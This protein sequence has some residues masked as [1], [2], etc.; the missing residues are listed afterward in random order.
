MRSI[1]RRAL[2]VCVAACVCAVIVGVVGAHVSTAQADGAGAPLASSAWPAFGHDIQMTRRSPYVGA[3]TNHLKWTRTTGAVTRASAAIGPDGTVYV[4]SG[5]DVVYALSPTDGSVQWTRS[6]PA[7]T[8]SSPAL[9]SDGTLFVGCYNGNLYA[10]DSS[11]GSVK[12]SAPVGDAVAYQDPTIGADGTVYC[13]SEQATVCAFD[14]G[15]GSLEWSRAMHASMEH[16]PSIGTTGTVYTGGG[17]VQAFDPSTGV[18]E[19]TFYP[20]GGLYN[21]PS[22]GADGTLYFGTTAGTVYALD[23][24]TQT[25]K[26]TQSV[27]SAVWTS[28]AIDPD[29]T[30]Y[31]G[32]QDG[33]LHALDSSNGSVKWSAATGAGIEACPAIGSDGT[34]YVANDGGTVEA[35]NPADGSVKWSYSAGAEVFSSPAIG[36]DGTVYV[37]SDN[38]TFYAFGTTETATFTLAYYAGADGS[39][40]GSSTQVVAYNTSGSAVTAQANA[41]YHF[42]KWSDGSTANPRTDTHVTVSKSVTANFALNTSLTITQCPTRARHARNF[43]IRGTVTPIF[44]HVQITRYRWLHRRWVNYGRYNV[45]GAADGTWVASV[46]ALYTGAWKFTAVANGMSATRYV[47]AY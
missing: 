16:A 40:V 37:G 10:I 8:W 47:T 6:L 22:V 38:G 19:W 35:L 23:P 42:V 7:Q 27:G 15:N 12:W 20:V 11:D 9:A 45:A 32:C 17:A 18:P 39:I 21:A 36:A 41:G 4:G 30:I 13:A 26:W 28:P 33:S 25:P 31:V 46:S 44:S 2:L 14:P 29:G 1:A 43:Q 3:Q 5:S 24:S 34:V